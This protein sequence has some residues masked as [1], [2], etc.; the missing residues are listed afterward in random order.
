MDGLAFLDRLERHSPRP[1][2]VIYGD[3]EFVRRLVLTS[4]RGLVLATPDDDFG[5]STY[6]GDKADFASIRAE[7]DTLPFLG[8]KRLVVVDDADPFVTRF[9]PALE[10][11][12]S[13]PSRSGT[14]VLHV[15]SWPSNTRLAKLLD[16][17]ATMQCNALP[18]SKLPGWCVEWAASQHRKQLSQPAARLLVDLIGA[19]MGQLDQ[20]LRKLAIF[21]DHADKIDVDD[22][23]RLVGN[24]RAEAIWK[25]F[26]A[27]G[28]ARMDE[29]LGILDRLFEQGEEPLR[30]LG[31]FSV[32]LRR[33]AQANR[34]CEGGLALPR[35]L[36]RA[37]VP[38][39]ARRGCEQQIQH[40]GQGRLRRL[41]EWL[42]EADLGL[43][44]SSQLSPRT[45]LERLVLRLAR[46]PQPAP[47]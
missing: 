10:R 43:K 30:I 26:D 9:R 14:L 27:I 15:K 41:Y 46:K 33:L 37:G 5:L 42:L 47:R 20:E 12:F 4:L 38:P 39:F 34:L 13:E 24:S 2:Y 3:E 6:A 44:G 22:V 18:L 7:L 23:D 16:A 25:I 1:V 19:E 8:S 31:A 36:E 17:E 28:A 35:A 45:L 29:A 11:Y 32:Q 21:V 40:L